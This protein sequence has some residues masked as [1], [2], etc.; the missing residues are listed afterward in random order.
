MFNRAENI[1]K[2]KLQNIFLRK[3]IFTNEFKLFKRKNSTYLSLPTTGERPMI[4][5]AK[6]DFTCWL[7]STTKSYEQNITIAHLNKT[8]HACIYK[9]V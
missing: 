2:I 6:A 7:G 8:I 3:K 4:T 5:D 1:F 9:Y